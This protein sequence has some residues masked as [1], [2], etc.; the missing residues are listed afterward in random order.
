[1]RLT[2]AA[3]MLI[4]TS[5]AFAQENIHTDNSAPSDTGEHIAASTAP[6]TAPIIVQG[7]EGNKQE[8]LVGS[9]IP[10]KAIFGDGIASS[11]GTR[12]LVPQSGMDQGAG[13]RTI[14]RKECKS[15]SPE[16]GKRAACIL[17]DAELAIDRG[18]V[19]RAQDLLAYLTLTPEFTPEE[20]LAGAEW[21]YRLAND[22]NDDRSRDV[23]LEQMIATGAMQPDQEIAARR[24][25]VSLALQDNQRTLARQRLEH[26]ASA[27]QASSRELA[28]LAILLREQSTGEP[29]QTMSRAIATAQSEGGIVPQ[30]WYDFV[31][32]PDS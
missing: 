20:R 24:M 29:I 9:R 32:A 1:M 26:I 8:V 5:T 6:T 25:L 2:I 15:D 27:N 30:G 18:E 17:I 19:D 10:Q 16:V 14:R 3:S 22:R 13:I 23:A 7:E 31:K 12:G 11:L 4:W 28:N 21:Q